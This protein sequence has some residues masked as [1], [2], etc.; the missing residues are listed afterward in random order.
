MTL[1]FRIP[2]EV[3]KPFL[4]A[5]DPEVA[6]TLT[7]RALKCGMHPGFDAI[8]DARL[9]MTV[10]DR[11]FPNPVG[12]AAGFDKNAEVPAE[13]LSMG[14]GFVEVGGVTPT[15]Q[16]GLPKPRIFR[17][18]QNQAV[19]NKMNFP[20]VGVQKF[21]ENIQTFLNKKPRPHGVLGIQIAMSSG[22]K[23]PAKDFKYM[24]RQVGLLADYIVFNVSCPNTP[25]LGD[26]QRKE[27]F[28]HLAKQI[29]DERDKVCKGNKTPVIVKLSPDLDQEQQE[30]LAE[31]CLNVKIDGVTLTNTTTKRPDYLEPR[32]KER[33]G[34]LSGQPL[35]ERSTEVIRNFYRLTKGEI[36]IIGV[37][38][39]SNA[40]QAYDK[41]KAGASLIQ[42]YSALVY[43][44][45]E[46]VNIIN[47]GLLKLM[48]QDG[49]KHLSEAVGA[50]H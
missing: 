36:P 33:Q 48:E 25:G 34:G 31:A 12:L 50:D 19:I 20:N 8:D 4:H 17:D 42:L 13:M 35:T 2:F 18:K 22:S 44:G 5:L 21:K 38:G 11:N 27:L 46:V 23:D 24:I 10:W 26:L 30:A 41:I 45:P 28:D 37:G 7:L 6:H 39:I 3:S 32:F 47:S 9:K 1:P 40:Q 16:T 14:F 15:P 43:Q 29:L 49:F